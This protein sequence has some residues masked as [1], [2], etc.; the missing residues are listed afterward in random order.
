MGTADLH[1]HSIYS[2]DGTVTI[3]GILK[4]ASSFAGLDVVAITDHD[5]IEGA[6]EAARLASRFNI[7]VIPGSEITT[8]DGHLLALF[9]QEKIE[10]GMSLIDTLLAIRE[11]NGLAIAAHPAA[12][13]VPSLTEE[14]ITEATRHGKAAGVFTGIETCNAGLIHRP[15]NANAS[16]IADNLQM[17][18]C[19]SSDSHVVWTIGTAVTTFPGH[20]S[21]DL[22]QALL[23][24]TTR[25]V[26]RNAP[27]PV[28]NILSWTYHAALRRGGWV[29]SFTGF[30][31]PIGLVR[32]N[33]L[34]S[35]N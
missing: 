31:N 10:P 29:N 32:L 19:G 3:S 9:I 11:Q 6:L 2:H 30:K 25:A 5:E 27:G 35:G 1:I 16:R 18:Q 4:Y 20:T 22:R 8:E 7:D 24:K 28:A 33:E 23:H 17:A 34:P 12:R 13:W 14:K 15:S 21:G 26:L